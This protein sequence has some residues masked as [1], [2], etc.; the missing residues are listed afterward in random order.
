MTS[1]KKKLDNLILHSTSAFQT[2]N[3]VHIN[4]RKSAE[5]LCKL[6]IFK[7]Y[8]EE[9]GS[10]ILYRQDREWNSRLKI[11]KSQQEKSHP[12]VLN[13]LIQVC[14]SKAILRSCYQKDYQDKELSE[15]IRNTIIYL[16]SIL[17]ALN[18]RGNSAAHESHRRPL[19]AETTQNLLREILEW[20]F[21][22]FLKID[23]PS[24]LVAYIGTYDIFIS[25]RQED[26]KWVEIL[27]KNL[28]LHGY[29]LYIDNYEL[30]SGENTKKSL[31][32]AIKNSRNAIEVYPEKDD[33]IWIKNE[34]EWI[35]EKKEQ[36]SSFNS[37]PLVIHN[38]TNLPPENIKYTDFSN[39]NYL[40]AFNQLLCSLERV[41]SSSNHIKYELELPNTP[42]QFVNEVM[43][44]LDIEKMVI[45]FSQESSDIRKY[46]R[47]IKEQLKTKFP[48]H[49][50]TL[51]IPSFKKEKRYFHSIAENCGIEEK[52][53]SLQEWKTA[54]QNKL[55]TGENILLFITDLDSGKEEC[56]RKFASTLRNLCYQ[57]S[58]N[59]YIV[60]VGHKEL[61]KL[62]FQEGDLSPLRSIGKHMFFPYD[63]SNISYE[64]LILIMSHSLISEH[65]EHLFKLLEKN[66]LQRFSPWSYDELINY[67]FWKG[68][69]IHKDGYLVWRN[70]ELQKIIKEMFVLTTI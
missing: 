70:E 18:S 45:L 25:Y 64:E 39:Q 40:Q 24:E 33:S 43:E 57:F 54:M 50:Y 29:K 49:F 37:I 3:N 59:L 65:K 34:R 51:S 41:P 67:L 55:S 12:M 2:N 30:I 22:D 9:R 15:V 19:Y 53:E 17:Y 5:A 4:A 61:A 6:M 38:S 47:P 21:K 8:G 44:Y 69:L 36:D 56:N 42:N 23:I 68:V 27:K 46:Y 32:H 26:E 20:L 28:L 52:V 66:Q 16:E 58:D 48:N 62:V 14:T 11:T 10:N 35:K 63:N 13:M 60:L 1:E 7:H 31:R